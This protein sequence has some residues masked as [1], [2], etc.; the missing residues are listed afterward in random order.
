[1]EAS[2]SHDYNNS[3]CGLLSCTNYCCISEGND[4]N[5]YYFNFATGES[6]WEHPCDEFYRKLLQQEREKKSLSGSVKSKHTASAAASLGKKGNVS[7]VLTNGSSLLTKQ[8]GLQPLDSRVNGGGKSALVGRSSKTYF[9]SW[10]P[11][12]LQ[13]SKS[14]IL[15]PLTTGKSLSGIGS[16]P[17]LK[18]APAS[19]APLQIPSG[20][21]HLYYLLLLRTLVQPCWFSR[22]N[23]VVL[24]WPLPPA[25]Q[26]AWCP[27]ETSCLTVMGRPWEPSILAP[28]WS[29]TS[30]KRRGV[31]SLTQRKA[32]RV[33]VWVNLSY[34]YIQTSLISFLHIL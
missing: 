3:G 6:T 11:F 9:P 7:R 8:D 29:P 34:N 27:V 33:R 1:M 17:L 15:A 26:A 20:L 32:L 21:V 23:L 31:Q 25:R 2:V 22:V 28:S 24:G 12:T 13:L 4:G 30:T 19:L 10:W 16:L 5:I 18:K 14:E